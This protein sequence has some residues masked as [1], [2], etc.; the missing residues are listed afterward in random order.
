[1]NFDV[2]LLGEC[3]V[4]VQELVKRL[5]KKEDGNGWVLKHE[6]CKETAVSIRGVE[7]CAARWIIEAKDGAN[8]EAVK[9]E[10]DGAKSGS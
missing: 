7:G 5:G 1:M 8:T 10:Q 9:T 4:V 2:E 6:M 3:D